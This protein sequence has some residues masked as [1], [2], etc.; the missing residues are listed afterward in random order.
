MEENNST[1]KQ[2]LIS[3]YRNQGFDG[4]TM[5]LIMEDIEAGF[6]QEQIDSYVEKQIP[7]DMKKR[8]SKA[9]H[10]DLIQDI[11]TRLKGL[12]QDRREEVMKAYDSGVPQ[13]VILDMIRRNYSAF[14]MK[15]GLENYMTDLAAFAKEKMLSDKKNNNEKKQ[16]E[17]KHEEES[18]PEQTEEKKPAPEE[19]EQEKTDLP[20]DDSGEE[21][22]APSGTENDILEKCVETMSSTVKDAISNMADANSQMLKE[23]FAGVREHDEWLLNKVVEGKTEKKEEKVIQVEETKPEAKSEPKPEPAPLI[24]REKEIEPVFK[25]EKKEESSSGLKADTY[26]QTVMLPNGAIYPIF[27]ERT[28]PVKPAGFMK[29]AAGLFKKDVPAKALINQLIDKKLNK[30]QLLQILRAVRLQFSKT[31]LTDLIESDL[32]A[33]EMESIINVVLAQRGQLAGVM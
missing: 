11:Y 27:I 22:S 9:I 13:E 29:R 31:E 23:M 32:P 8:I 25:D 7:L 4:E 24:T 12:T 5:A 18:I 33:D 6:K 1:T 3:W 2:Q 17:V 28:E 15:K 10:K 19:R 20:Q 21:I 14:H 26:V 30:E 16:E